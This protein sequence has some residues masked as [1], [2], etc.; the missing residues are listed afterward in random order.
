MAVTPSR[1][2]LM[3]NQ[4]QSWQRGYLSCSTHCLL[5]VH[6]GP[7]G[8]ACCYS[9]SISNSRIKRV[10]WQ[11]GIDDIALHTYTNILVGWSWRRGV[12]WG[13][14]LRSHHKGVCHITLHNV[15]FIVKSQTNNAKKKT[16]HIQS[17]FCSLYSQMELQKDSSKQAFGPVVSRLRSKNK[18]NG[19]SRI[20]AGLWPEDKH[21]ESLA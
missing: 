11:V 6:L 19:T 3:M 15:T 16:V 14:R 4:F 21:V 12:D 1:S 18:W 8:Y 10:P 2:R 5:R 20:Y 17:R 9:C 7:K 13:H